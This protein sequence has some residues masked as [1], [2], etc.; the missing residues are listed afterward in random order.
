MCCH[1]TGLPPLV[2]SKNGTPNCRSMKSAAS[3][4]ASAVVAIISSGAVANCPHTNSGM[5]VNVIPGARIFKIVTT[6]L[7]PVMVELTP[8][9]KIAAHHI[10]VPAAPCNDTGGYSI[11]PAV[12]APIKN[13]ENNIKPETGKIQKLIILSHGK[14]TSR[15]PICTG[16]TRLPK[17]PVSIGMITSHTMALPW[18]LYTSLYVPGDTK[19]PLGLSS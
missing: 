9:K 16:K 19:P 15:A 7:M 17:P 13:E 14:A 2:G 4:A 6:K 5:R 1:I 3:A 8:T 12:G 10:E 11:Q 18:T